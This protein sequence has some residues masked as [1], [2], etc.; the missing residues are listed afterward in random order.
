MVISGL[1]L[2]DSEA[3]NEY[4]NETV[5]QNPLLSQDPGQ[6]AKQRERGRFHDTRL[7]PAQRA[8]Y[9]CLPPHPPDPTLI[10]RQ[11]EEISTRLTQLAS[12]LAPND[13]WSF[14]LGDCGYPATFAWLEAITPIL[15]LKIHWPQAI[16]D[17]R[18]W[19]ASEPAVD[20][21]LRDLVPAIRSW[22][23]AR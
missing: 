12:L 18:N 7:E 1:L 11:S 14:S 20:A 10:E 3:I 17:Y 21:E 6:R 2:S 9:R 23:S 15:S 4:L 13:Q 19:L 5:P 16:C 22:L 8:L